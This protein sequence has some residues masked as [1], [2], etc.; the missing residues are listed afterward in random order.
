MDGSDT[1]EH[2]L[3]QIGAEVA[4][5]QHGN[6]AMYRSMQTALPPREQDLMPAFAIDEGR[7]KSKALFLEAKRNAAQGGAASYFD[8]DSD[9]DDAD[10]NA[11][12]RKNNNKKKREKA[13][14]AKAKAKGG[15]GAP[16]GPKK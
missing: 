3:T 2:L 1:L 5:V 6:K 16:G 7:D 12:R 4:L 13:A 10:A 15:D 14:A 8:T 9:S 11:R